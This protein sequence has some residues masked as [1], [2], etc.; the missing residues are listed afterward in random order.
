MVKKAYEKPDIS[1]FF[2]GGVKILT[3]SKDNDAEDKEWTM[4]LV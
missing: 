1:I 4:D 3:L 2:G